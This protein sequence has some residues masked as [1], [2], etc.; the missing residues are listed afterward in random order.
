MKELRCITQNATA[1]GSIINHLL[2]GTKGAPTPAIGMGCTILMM[3]DR[4]AGTII[5]VSE[6][7]RTVVMQQDHAELVE[8]RISDQ[9]VYTY[10]PN[11]N[12]RKRTFTLRKN[13]SYVE[14]GESLNGT[15]LRIGDRRQYRDPSF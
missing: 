5:E 9:Q 13:G 2:S 11:L 1:M 3:T 6:N 12:S 10:A 4:H 8:K 14:Q 15:R 7:K